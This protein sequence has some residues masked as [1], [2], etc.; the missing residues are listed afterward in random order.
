MAEDDPGPVLAQI[1]SAG[2]AL[3]PDGNTAIYD[4]LI[5]AYGVAE[6]QIAADPDRFT[7]I[8]LMTGKGSE[9]IAVKALQAGA[10]SYVPK[11]QLAQTLL[12]LAGATSGQSTLF[13]GAGEQ[14]EIGPTQSTA[15]FA[16]RPRR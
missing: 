7:S 13:C 6:R 15:R 16:K 11:S 3:V 9:E 5:A 2:N 4:S 10:A 12:T 8:V 14:E 1:A